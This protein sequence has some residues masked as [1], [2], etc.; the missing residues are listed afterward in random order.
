MTSVR[1]LGWRGASGVLAIAIVLPSAA[2]A[3]ELSSRLGPQTTYGAGSTGFAVLEALTGIGLLAAA[4]V[5]LADRSTAT[6]GILAGAGTV[7]W[8]A[9]V[10]V[11]WEEG[12]GLVRA[13]G[14]VVA[15]LLPAAVLAIALHTA[16]RA[17]RPKA[18]AAALTVI[19]ATSAFAAALALA[20]VREPLRDP[21]CWA[22][23]T[24]G[25]F[26]VHDDIDLAER[27]APVTLWVTM[28]CG[29]LAA[30]VGLIRLARLRAGAWRSSAP[31]LAAAAVAGSALAAYAVA[32]RTAGRES[33]GRPLFEW[34]FVAR[35]VALL[36]LAAGLLW[37]ALR[38]R[39]VRALVTR[40]AVDLERTAEEGGVGRLLSRAVGDPGL[41]L[42]YPIGADGRVVDAEGRPVDADPARTTALVADGGVVALVE[43]DMTLADLLERELG[44][45]AQL[46]LG[47]ER[48]RAEAL[49][50]LADASAS[51]ARVVD[52]ADSERRRIERDLHDGAQQ[53]LL[54]LTY[55][56]R[57][58]L[59]AAESSGE[60]TT[61]ANLRVAL[62][63]AVAAST[64][65]RDIAHG[66]FPAE[67]AASGL[68]AALE[69]LADVRP[70]RLTVD[71]PAARRYAPRIEAAAY[72]LAAEATEDESVVDVDVA[73]SAGQVR[74]AVHAPTDDDRLVRLEDRAAAAG[75]TVLRTASGI[76]ATVPAVTAEAPRARTP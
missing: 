30:L 63:S 9:P 12:P 11:G 54:S 35:A 28:A 2:L 42:R 59:A 21:G 48:L 40:L 68:A 50:R 33:P 24:A 67:L 34:L 57:V 71:L 15:P 55:D 70:I 41:R 65:L 51:R 45:A 3:V 58:A 22:D 44:P 75:G 23:C 32:L 27:V 20:L 76:E 26:A 1:A 5:L 10:W 13:V 37:L 25:A 29:A 74:I 36:T 56:L 60:E 19:A 38:P 62:E 49:A 6:L 52:A 66:I 46:A 14:L 72:A 17:R 64:E 61:A 69:S 4:L 39:L 43:S 7:T 73:E 53:R 16:V 47:N 8:F 31:V 18:A